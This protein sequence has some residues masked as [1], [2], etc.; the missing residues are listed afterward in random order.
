MSSSETR[1]LRTALRLVKPLSGRSG[2]IRLTL[3]MTLIL[4]KKRFRSVAF[5]DFLCDAYRGNPLVSS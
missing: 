2:S 1:R 5:T 4:H 3:R